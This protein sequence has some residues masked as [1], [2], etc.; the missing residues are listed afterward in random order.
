MNFVDQFVAI[1]SPSAGI[2]RAQ[3]RKILAKIRSYDGAAKGGHRVKNWRANSSG[4]NVANS[5]AMVT[6]RNRARDLERNSPIA[7]RALDVIVSNVVGAG[8]IPEAKGR[9]NV[10]GA[11]D[12]ARALDE[13]F[14]RWGDTRE[15]DADGMMDFYA[16][17]GLVLRSVVRDGEVF[18]RKRR[19]RMRDR[20][21]IPMQLQVLESDFCDESKNETLTNGGVIIN[22]VEFDAIGRVRGYW[23]F[24][25][26]PAD[27]YR[28]KDNFTSEFIPADEIIHVFRRDRPGQV[29]GISWFAPVMV[30]IREL[31]DAVDFELVRRKT[32]AAFAGF[33][34]D[35]NLDDYDSEEEVELASHIEPGTMEVLPPGRDVKF[36]SPPDAAGF[37]EFERI[38]MHHI[39]AGLGISYEALTSDLTG[40]NFSSARVGRLEFQRNIDIWRHHLIIPQFCVPVLLEFA[41]I[42]EIAT[43]F[44]ADGVFFVHTPPKKE[45]IDPRQE[46]MALKD[47]MRLGVRSLPDVIREMGHDPEQ[48][49]DEIAQSNKML[50]DR[51][52]V[53]DSDPR[54]VTLSGNAFDPMSPGGESGENLGSD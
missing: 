16:L 30:K 39:A 33:I 26:H 2:R 38:Q 51:D 53:L 48:V 6:L 36:S 34:T 20:L 4:A 13:L 17:Q 47:A 7:R 50:D 10:Q 44:K 12:R 9:E 35:S 21:S 49:L 18:I 1:F 46:L 8:I 31:Q 19:R 32:T 15:I 28:N 27:V 22:G 5:S 54:K 25:T 45:F 29:R 52:L 42:A 37:G 14:V 40:V 24:K 43:D 41:R 23:M 11:T 3:E